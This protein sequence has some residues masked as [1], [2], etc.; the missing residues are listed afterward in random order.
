[1]VPG[2]TNDQQAMAEVTAR[3]LLEIEAVLFRPNDPFT[4][5]SARASPVYV[6][7]R[8]I[9]SFPRARAQLMDFA[10]ALI[11]RQIGYESIDCIAG[12]ETAGIPFAAWIAERLGL[13]M[14]YVR[15]K[16]KG[17]GRNAQIE[18]HLPEGSRVLLVEDLATDGG[19]KLNFVDAIR[20]ADAKIAHTF[21]IFHYGIF[22]EGVAALEERGVTLHALA[23]WWDA[24]GVAEQAG[25]LAGDEVE[26]VRRFL[27]DPETWTPNQQA[28]KG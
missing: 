22:P 3:I 19:S 4:L 8:R 5:T 11:Q 28:A 14:L 20:Q 16:P 17:F 21:V 1:M 27:Q 13:P 24:L 10:C 26:E 23:T 25:Y 2:S 6:D 9:I 18:G 15:K 7:C 12:G